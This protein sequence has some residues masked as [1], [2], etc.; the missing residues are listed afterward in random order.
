MNFIHCILEQHER[1]ILYRD[2]V[3]ERWVEPGRHRFSSWFS[4]MRLERI[5]VEQGFCVATPEILKMA[6][7]EVAQELVVKP[8]HIAV[9]TMD[10]QPTHTLSAGRYIL[11]QARAKVCAWCFDM[12]EHLVSLEDAYVKVI[13]AHLLT[14][15]I[16]TSQQ[17]GVLICDG[18]PV[19]WLMP[20]RHHVWSSTS[21]VLVRQ[22]DLSASV[23]DLSHQEDVRALIPDEDVLDLELA[24]NQIAIVSIDGRLAQCL[25]PGRYVLWQQL[26]EVKATV[27]ATD[28]LKTKLP[29]KCWSLVG[30]DILTVFT[31]HPYMRG[32]LYVDGKRQDVLEEGRYGFH[33]QDREVDLRLVD[34]REQELQIQGQ[35]VMTADKV[36]LR[37]NLIVK[38]RIDDAV[39]SVEGNLDLRN[40]LYSEVQMAARRFI[41][42]VSIDHL[43][44]SRNDVS[45]S[46]L[47]DVS[48]RAQ[49]WGAHVVQVD[50]KDLILPGEMKVLLNRVIEAEKQAAAHNIMRRE[51]TAATRSQANTAKMLA[52]NP[53]LMRLKELEAMREI[54]AQIDSIKVVAGADDV[55]SRFSCMSALPSGD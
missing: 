44:E 40:A 12:K 26:R 33:I 19:S 42:G 15:H 55:I 13:P 45:Q 21:Q 10:G 27:Y 32:V 39:K 20:G 5:N 2:G 41:A 4:T 8:N 23:L 14:T 38:F 25:K 16:I 3:P 36:T 17:R 47:G 50:L 52:N 28:Q 51:E 31:V 43:L 9:I 35:E 30:P 53:V 18:C 7:A 49:V 24:H 37:T 22:L 6:P 11:W 48:A 29:E 1:G 34:M 54:A 46:M